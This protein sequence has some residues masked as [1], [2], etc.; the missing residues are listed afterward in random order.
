MIQ[1]EQTLS[2]TYPACFIN[3][4]YQGT[5]NKYVLKFAYTGKNSVC[6]KFQDITTGDFLLL[7]DVLNSTRFNLMII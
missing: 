6:V 4:S 2:K 5:N 7:S 1:F 3:L